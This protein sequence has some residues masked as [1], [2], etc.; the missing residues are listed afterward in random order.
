MKASDFITDKE[1]AELFGL[2]IQ[3]LRHHCMKSF[4]CPKGK[5]DVR[6]ALPVV[7]GRR[8]LW[9]RQRIIDLLN[10]PTEIGRN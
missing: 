8:R 3:T 6:N 4:V 5:V 10:T 1:A 7:V 2:G 9:N